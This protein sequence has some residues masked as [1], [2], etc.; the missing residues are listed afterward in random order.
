MFPDPERHQSISGLGSGMDFSLPGQTPFDD[1]VDVGKIA[2]SFF[3]GWTRRWVCRFK[4][5]FGKEEQG[6]VRSPPGSVYREKPQSGAGQIEQMAVCVGHQFVWFFW[7][8]I[9]GHRVVHVVMNGKRHVGVGTVDR[10][11]GSKYEVFNFMIPAAFQNIDESDQVRFNIGLRIGQWVSHPRLSGQ[12]DNHI[13]TVFL[14]NLFQPLFVGQ[15][16]SIKPEQGVRFE[17]FQPFLL[18]LRIIVIVQVINSENMVSVI[19]ESFG[20]VET[21]KAGGAGN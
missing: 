14:E 19:E 11:G 8:R 6:H 1:I 13:H 18:E 4:D 17:Y 3:H 21:D 16:G 12:I 5:G 9:Q 10:T 2:S 15:I 7:R 20:K